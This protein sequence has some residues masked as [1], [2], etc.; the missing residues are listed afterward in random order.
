M[1]RDRIDITG[2]KFGRWTV[3][4]DLPRGLWLCRCDCGA[5]GRVNSFTLRSSG[6]TQCTPCAR[7]SARIFRPGYKYEQWTVIENVGRNKTR[8][9]CSCGYE[10]VRNDMGV[11]HYRSKYCRKCS[12]IARRKSPIGNIWYRL[13]KNALVRDI[14]LLITD[15]EAF[16]LLEAQG[17]K[18]ALSG[19]PIKIADT[20]KSHNLERGTTASLD[21]IDSSKPYVVGNIQWVHKAVNRMKIDFPQDEFIEWCRAI[22]AHNFAALAEA[23]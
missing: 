6:S 10:C 16:A 9:R 1:R 5:E 21:R 15:A 13:R 22:A 18:C 7:A 4:K 14:P 23:A 17:Y 2:Q 19:V 8:W 20:Q 11:L 3:V 12:A